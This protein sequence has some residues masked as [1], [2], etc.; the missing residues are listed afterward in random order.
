MDHA[1]LSAESPTTPMHVG[2]IQIFEAGPLR[3]EEGGIDLG[4]I[5]SAY[6][7]VLDQV[8]RYR[9]TLEWIPI[10]DRA[11]WAD[12][13]HFNIDYHVRHVALPKPGGMAE[14]RRVAGRVLEHHLDRH[15]PLWEIWIVEGL[16]S[17]HFALIAKTHHCMLDGSAGVELAQTLLSPAPDTPLPE[18]SVY[19]PRPRPTPRE[20]LRDQVR[21]RMLLPLKLMRGLRQ[22]RAETEDLGAEIRVRMRAFRELMGITMAEPTETPINGPLGPHRRF[23]WMTLQ[24]ADVKAVRKAL[25]CTLNDVVLATVTEAVRRFL[26]ARG[27]S[28]EG[29]VFRASTPVNV[30]RDD[31]QGVMGNRVSSWIF[32]LPV[33]ES[34]RK[35]QVERVRETTQA[36][37]E[38]R[39]A[40]G[41]EMAM[42]ATELVPQGIVSR[43]ANMAT[44]PINI[45]V[46]NVPGPQF[47]LYMLGAKLLAMIPQVPLVE[48]V[49]LGI[50]LMSY[51]GRVFF[52]FTADYELVPDL[53]A[54][55]ELIGE[56]FAELAA[57]AGVTLSWPEAEQA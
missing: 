9:Q 49:G 34:D 25:G 6:E 41:I 15:K 43:S 5:R 37:K 26:K 32:E 18:A 4:A 7:A 2:A 8:P 29:M 28:P 33:G 42:A 52:G 50:A 23:D 19:V 48:N 36:L 20:L 13:H 55:V 16:E 57:V 17:D 1:F 51:D 45:I 24:L 39:Q 44:G 21:E 40:L 31:E 46:T 10:E 12:D 47:P 53:D 27:A 22:A 14:L 56:S 38:S 35:R 30:R 54:F 3:N 11:V